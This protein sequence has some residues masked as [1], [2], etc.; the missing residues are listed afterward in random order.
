MYTF[1]SM[2]MYPLLRNKSIV[3]KS[4]NEQLNKGTISVRED[5]V[6]D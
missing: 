1:F 2:L 5:I 4:K 6:V 3:N